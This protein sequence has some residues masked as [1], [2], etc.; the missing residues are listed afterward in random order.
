MEA[1]RRMENRVD[2]WAV[3]PVLTAVYSGDTIA[4]IDQLVGGHALVRLAAA[5]LLT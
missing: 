4:S 5:H 1:L 2:Y 3:S